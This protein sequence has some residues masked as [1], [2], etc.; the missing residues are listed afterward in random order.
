M[1]KTSFK[2]LDDASASNRT[3]DAFFSADDYFRERSFLF[4]ASN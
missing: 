3:I 4:Y 1:N 2:S